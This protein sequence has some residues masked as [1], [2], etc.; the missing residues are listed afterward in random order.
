LK[1]ADF[2]TGSRV[3][4][5]A[6]EIAEGWSAFYAREL[7]L[8]DHL[9]PPLINEAG[10]ACMTAPSAWCLCRTMELELR[11]HLPRMRR[12]IAIYQP[13]VESVA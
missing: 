9:P 6:Q 8:R 3:A 11:F 5:M 10:R 7:W 1:Q 12:L 2:A 13:Y 4:L